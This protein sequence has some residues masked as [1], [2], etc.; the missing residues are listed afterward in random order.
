MRITSWVWTRKKEKPNGTRSRLA[1]KSYGEFLR[2]QDC[3]TPR[4]TTAVAGPAKSGFNDTAT[5]GLNLRLG[6]FR[7]LRELDRQGPSDLPVAEELDRCLGVADQPGLGEDLRVDGGDRRVE[8]FKVCEVHDRE[9]LAE[10]EVAESAAR[11]ASIKG[12]VAGFKTD[13]NPSARA[14]F[15][16]LVTLATSFA[17]TVALT[18]SQAAFGA[19]RPVAVDNVVQFHD[20]IS[21]QAEPSQATGAFNA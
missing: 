18:L 20:G 3:S 13:P 2:K 21:F 15:L 11:Q 10:L 19:V 12:N 16:P 14:C 7:N 4:E 8:P 17:V 5:G 1:I 9:L 6:R